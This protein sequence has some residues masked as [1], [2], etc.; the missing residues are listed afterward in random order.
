MSEPTAEME[1]CRYDMSRA[2]QRLLKGQMTKER[3]DKV[4]LSL[5]LRMKEMEEQHDPI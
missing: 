5:E 3:Y 2:Y 1:A 4:M